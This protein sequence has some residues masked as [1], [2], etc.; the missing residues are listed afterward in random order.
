MLV[1]M[2]HHNQE[3]HTFDEK[4]SNM[5]EPN[6]DINQENRSFNEKYLSMN[7]S[8]TNLSQIFFAHKTLRKF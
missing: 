5:N 8:S 3:N 7:I 2:T 4:H 1:L 6:K